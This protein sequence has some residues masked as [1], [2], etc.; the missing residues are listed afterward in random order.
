MSE[1][2]YKRNKQTKNRS[3]TAEEQTTSARDAHQE[4]VQK[5]G[6]NADGDV[7]IKDMSADLVKIIDTFADYNVHGIYGFLRVLLH[8][9]WK[10]FRRIFG[11]HRIWQRWMNNDIRNT[12][13]IFRVFYAN[14]DKAPFHE[15]I[16]Q[17][18]YWE[19]AYRTMFS[20]PFLEQYN[21]IIPKDYFN[22]N[23]VIPDNSSLELYNRI[24]L[25]N[26]VNN[27]YWFRLY[28]ITHTVV[29]DIQRNLLK[30]TMQRKDFSPAESWEN[31]V[32]VE[33]TGI[34]KIR[35]TR[36]LQERFAQVETSEESSEDNHG[37]GGEI[38]TDTTFYEYF[39]PKIEYSDNSVVYLFYS[40]LYSVGESVKYSHLSRDTCRNDPIR[41]LRE[42][43]AAMF[44][45]IAV[46]MLTSFFDS[47]VLVWILLTDKLTVRSKWSS[48][49]DVLRDDR[50]WMQAMEYYHGDPDITFDQELA[51]IGALQFSGWSAL[52]EANE[53]DQMEIEQKISYSK[54]HGVCSYCHAGTPKYKCEN[55]GDNFCSHAH[56]KSMGHMECIEQSR[57]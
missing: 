10:Y 54:Q 39:A 38:V 37:L 11:D 17:S 13:K 6:S 44:Q 35:V 20:T 25:P 19:N 22:Q 40:W 5:Y 46:E 7:P 3:L 32:N 12:A 30:Q 21:T 41:Q 33:Y 57:K 15:M 8:G 4:W 34:N 45:A 49:K 43:R 51:R 9:K 31:V 14:T 16:Q 42:I 23:V 29:E 1:K 26:A 27:T 2:R 53:H 56:Q 36:H 47:T 18:K 55:C 48:V 50:F 28:V 52:F 24:I